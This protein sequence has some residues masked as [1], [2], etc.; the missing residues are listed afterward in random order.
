MI[1]TRTYLAGLALSAA[2]FAAQA[3]ITVTPTVVS[4]YDFRGI[5]QDA[6][7]PALQVGVDWSG[8]PVHLGLWTSNIDFEAPTK[9]YGDKH[10]ELDLI[11]DYS[12]GSEETVKFNTGLVYYTYPGQTDNNTPEV[13]FMGTKGWFSAALH[14]SWDWFSVGGAPKKNEYY[15][16]VNGSW[17]LG[18][19]D[20]GFGLTAH[21]GYNGGDYYKLYYK[22]YTDYSVG[23]TK[24]LGHFNVGLKYID[25]S[26]PNL[27]NSE[28]I[29]VN[30]GR[31]ILSVSTT[32]PWAK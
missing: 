12:F 31:A 6:K 8:G 13:W 7:D 17:P 21:V 4:D 18:G 16:E 14:Y 10:T 27:A 9:F 11:G 15:A 19:A 26:G 23:V 24:S 5:T 28:D 32:F 3:G 25:N 29:L 1:R 22:E 20:S 30:D 2:A